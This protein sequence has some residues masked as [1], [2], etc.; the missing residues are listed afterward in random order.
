[1]A[2][3]TL[4]ELSRLFT[5]EKSTNPSAVAVIKAHA[6]PGDKKLRFTGTVGIGATTY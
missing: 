5:V 1:M 6:V 2:R 4:R 3:K